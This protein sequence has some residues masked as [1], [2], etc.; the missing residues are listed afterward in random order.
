MGVVWVGVTGGVVRMGVLSPCAPFEM[1]P[2]DI[3]RNLFFMT[4][5][6]PHFARDK[7]ET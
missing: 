5:G 6:S 2:H 4:R 1:Y 3:A 7:M